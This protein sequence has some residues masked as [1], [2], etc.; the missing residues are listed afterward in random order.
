MYL[1]VIFRMIKHYVYNISFLFR[2]NVKID[3]RDA[4]TGHVYLL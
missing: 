2:V 4:G 3:I 1:H